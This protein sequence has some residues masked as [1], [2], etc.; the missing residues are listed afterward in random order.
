[1]VYRKGMPGFEVKVT[2]DVPFL[3]ISSE[4]GPNGDQWENWIWVDPER[5]EPGEINGTIL[6]ETNDPGSKKISVP[7]TGKLLPN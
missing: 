3:K 6:I 5:A 2:S 1:M 7:V 4:R